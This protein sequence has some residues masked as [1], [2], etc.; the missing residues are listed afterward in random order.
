[1]TVKK[2]LEDTTATENDPVEFE[3]ELSKPKRTVSWYKN[4]K[5]IKTDSEFEMTSD[6]NVHRLQLQS[7]ELKDAGEYT[8]KVDGDDVASS[9]KL[10]V[11]GAFK[12][13]TQKLSENAVLAVF[14]QVQ[15]TPDASKR[16]SGQFV[17]LLASIQCNNRFHLLE[18][19]LASSVDWVT[20][21]VVLFVVKNIFVSSVKMF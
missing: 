14:M 21:T 15:S 5:P 8:V 2:G 19:A 10:T 11:Q 12:N 3:C 7:C 6:G 1:M 17:M 13:L 4:S 20:W 16:I 18:F 9:A